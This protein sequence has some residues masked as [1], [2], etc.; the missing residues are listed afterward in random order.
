[1]ERSIQ[2]PWDESAVDRLITL[3]LEEDLGAGDLT[4][5]VVLDRAMPAVARVRAKEALV[6]AGIEVVQR[7]Y[8]RLG[9]I[10]VTA[11]IAD[12]TR[13]EPGTVVLVLE[14]DAALLLAGERVALNLL[15]HLSGVATLTR[16]CVD[17]LGSTPCVLRDTRKT[18]PG[19]RSLEKYAVRVGGG[20]NHRLRLDDGVLIKD[21]HVALLGSVGAAVN[22]ARAARTGIE[23]EVECRTAEEVTQALGAGADVILLDNMGVIEMERAVRSV[24]GRARVEASGGVT[25]ERVREVA[26]TGVDYIAM[27]CLTHSAP[28]V[29]LSMTIE[30]ATVSE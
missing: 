28:A 5:R 25:P 13:V 8:A 18:L 22:A 16:R 4:S 2:S 9:P 29:D 12:G 11:Q 3:A 6:L 10:D 17:A 7:V 27:G 24:A 19:L 20:T 30:P 1:M 23:I 21:N 14:G 15:Q 26:G